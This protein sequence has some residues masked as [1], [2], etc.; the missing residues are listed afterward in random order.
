MVGKSKLVKQNVQV[1]EDEQGY[2]KTVFRYYCLEG[3]TGGA[4]R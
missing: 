4:S 2:L 3:K 1:M